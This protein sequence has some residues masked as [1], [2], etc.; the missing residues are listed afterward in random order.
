M[1]GGQNPARRRGLA[2]SLTLAAV[3][4][5]G[6]SPVGTRYLVGDG[7]AGLP[8]LPLLA[9]RYGIASI[10]LAPLLWRGRIAGLV[11]DWRLLLLCSL[12]GITGYNIPVTI[13]QEHVSAGMTGLLDSAEPL[14]IL[15][16]GAILARRLPG[17]L[18]LLAGAIG[19]VGVAMLALATGPAQGTPGGVALVLLGAAFWAAYCVAVP[20]LLLRRGAMPVTAATMLIGTLPMAALGAP[21]MTHLVHIMGPTDWAVTLILTLGTSVLAMLFWNFGSAVLGAQRSGW[22]LY[23]IPVASLLGGSTMLGEP[24]APAEIIG[25]VLIVASVLLAQKA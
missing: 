2:V 17:R 3:L 21:G 24:I 20:P 13:G 5:W 22:F 11:R 19:A 16:F 23:L 7:D 1:D 18:M 6:F 4:M 12:L 9:L 10:M 8:A 14:M 15:L 25:G